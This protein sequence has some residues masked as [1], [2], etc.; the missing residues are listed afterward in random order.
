MV[1]KH[2]RDPLPKGNAW[3]AKEA[4]QLVHLEICGPINPISNGKKR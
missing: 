3:G 1:G 2:N 4:L